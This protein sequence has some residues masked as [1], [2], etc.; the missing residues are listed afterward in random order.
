MK[1][2]FRGINIIHR[3]CRSQKVSQE[4]GLRLW[5]SY[6]AHLWFDAVKHKTIGMCVCDEQVGNCMWAWIGWVTEP[7]IIIGLLFH[8][9]QTDTLTRTTAHPSLSRLVCFECVLPMWQQNTHIIPPPT[10]LIWQNIFRENFCHFIKYADSVLTPC[11]RK[12]ILVCHGDN[13]QQ[14]AV[15]TQT[16]IPA[17]RQTVS[18]M[19]G[20]LTS[21]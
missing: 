8:S 4:V 1:N 17:S 20:C 2:T 10:A 3:H 5:L 12:E 9:T 21:F 16:G 7:L 15:H 19:L 14:T 6:S 13:G 11:S 18:T